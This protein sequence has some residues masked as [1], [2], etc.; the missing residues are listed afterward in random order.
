MNSRIF[1]VQVLEVLM[2]T[3]V[4]KNKQKTDKVFTLVRLLQ[5]PSTITSNNLTNQPNHEKSLVNFRDT[6]IS[7]YLP[8]E[9]IYRLKINQ[10]DQIYLK[11]F[12]NFYMNLFEE[13]IETFVRSNPESKLPLAYQDALYH[14]HFI[15]S[16][17]FH[18]LSKNSEC[19]MKAMR[20]YI[21][22]KQSDQPLVL[23][24]PIGSGKTTYVSTLAS[25]LYLHYIAN[26]NGSVNEANEN[27]LVMRFIGIDGN[28]VIEKVKINKLI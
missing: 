17:N 5:Q 25:N 24:G 26:Q 8:A 28:L 18:E 10:I 27:A 9:Q 2:T 14:F 1:L 4:F 16:N 3:G 15:K 13:L 21:F 6:D 22:D 19:V 12:E 23:T 7:Y 20:D 11:N